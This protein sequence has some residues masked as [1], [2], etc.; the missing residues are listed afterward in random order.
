MENRPER[1]EEGARFEPDEG[2]ERDIGEAEEEPKR[3]GI[4]ETFRAAYRQ[5]KEGQ[6][7]T[8]AQRATDNPLVSERA[9]QNRDRTKAMFVMR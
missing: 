7:R 3:G 4:G 9:A 2:P 1:I 5:V 6:P 8:I